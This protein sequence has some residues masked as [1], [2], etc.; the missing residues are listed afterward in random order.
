[1]F[2]VELEKAPERP[3]SKMPSFYTSGRTLGLPKIS[4]AVVKRFGS[5]S[6]LNVFAHIYVSVLLNQTKL[7]V[8]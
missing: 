4:Q 2:V 7:S 6:F 3:R 8:Y 5:V 1:M